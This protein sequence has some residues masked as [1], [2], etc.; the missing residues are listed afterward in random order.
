VWLSLCE[1]LSWLLAEMLSRDEN[2]KYIIE[3]EK[4]S[5]TPKQFNTSKI[6][7]IFLLKFSIQKYSGLIELAK[8]FSNFPKSKVFSLTKN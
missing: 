1:N 5:S 4:S 2:Y 8:N 3:R 7:C 6:D